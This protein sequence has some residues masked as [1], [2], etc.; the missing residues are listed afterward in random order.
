MNDNSLQKAVEVVINDL[1]SRLIALTVRLKETHERLAEIHSEAAAIIKEI[2]G[3]EAQNKYAKKRK[4][5]DKQYKLQRE[6]YVAHTTTLKAIEEQIRN[7][8]I[9]KSTIRLAE[10]FR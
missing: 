4:K 8:E 6:R 9:A 10:Y 2:S 3:L 1:D 7:A 5:L